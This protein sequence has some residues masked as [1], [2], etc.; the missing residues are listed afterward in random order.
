VV[1]AAL[2]VEPDE[3]PEVDAHP[4]TVIRPAP[5]RSWRIRRRLK[6]MS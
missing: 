5:P 1:A 4:T 3:E 6:A 2:G